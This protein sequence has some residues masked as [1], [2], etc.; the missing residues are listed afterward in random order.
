VNIFP[1]NLYSATGDNAETFRRLE[2]HKKIVF[3]V[4]VYILVIVVT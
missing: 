2:N 3:A 4:S 1:R